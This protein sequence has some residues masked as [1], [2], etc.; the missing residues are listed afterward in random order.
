MKRNP[1]L[2]FVLLYVSILQLN[3]QGVLPTEYMLSSKA[4]D[5]Y[6]VASSHMNDIQNYQEKSQKAT[7]PAH[8]QLENEPDC[9]PDYEDITNGGC[10]STPE[11]FTYLN[12]NCSQTVCGK[13]GN[14]NYLGSDYRDTDWYVFDLTDSSDVFIDIWAEF[15]YTV[16]LVDGTLGCL[17]YTIIDNISGLSNDTSQLNAWVGPGEYWIVVLPQHFSGIPCGSEYIFSF[18]TVADPI[19]TGDT[20]C[21]GE[22]A[23]LTATGSTGNYIWYEDAAGTIVLDEGATFITP[24]L[25]NTTTYYVAARTDTFT[26]YVGEDYSFTNCGAT[27]RYGPDQTQVNNTYATTNLAGAVTINTQGIQEWTVPYSGYYRIEA[28]GAQGGMYL[29]SPGQGAIMAGD[30]YLNAGDVLHILVGQRGLGG[31][32]DFGFSGGGGS[33]VALSG[34]TPLLVAGGGGTDYNGVASLTTILGQTTML[35]GTAGAAVG[36]AGDGGNSL[37]NSGGGGGFNTNGA[38]AGGGFAFVNGGAGSYSIEHTFTQGGFGGGGVRIG[39]FGEGCG[40]GYSGGNGGNNVSVWQGGSGGGSYLDPSM[41]NAA[42]SNGLYENLNQLNGSITDLAQYNEGNGYVIVTLLPSEYVCISD[43][44]PVVVQVDDVPG[45]PNPING[46]DTVC[47]ETNSVPYSTTVVPNTDLYNWYYS[48]TG[49]TINGNTE[50]VTLDFSAS[51][52]SGILTVSAENDCGEGFESDNFYIEVDPCDAGIL[53]N[54]III[55]VEIVPNPSEGQFYCVFYSSQPETFRMNIT[56]ITGKLV[57][58]KTVNV[59]VGVNKIEVD[60]LHVSDGTYLLQ[61]LSETSV[62]RTSFIISK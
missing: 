31:F 39:S 24:V 36:S 48:G 28:A 40:G 43:P 50:A 55:Q 5:G 19:A 2:L 9:I 60:M 58:T 18:S 62:F 51:A 30:I 13:S 61:G 37:N 53:E 11:V 12:S 42:T 35:G 38:T 22:T 44:I 45:Q 56:D 7:C 59:N 8:A 10:N 57:W 27:G 54:D 47:V 23:T 21:A 52:T 49:V 34:T 17:A 14:Y 16:F 6:N 29:A 33:F 4:P 25:T 32:Y 20:I 26:V 46:S 1:I 15:D 3:A 41:T